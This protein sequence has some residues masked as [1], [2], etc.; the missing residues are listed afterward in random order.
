MAYERIEDHEWAT[1]IES[2]SKYLGGRH[3]EI[4][5]MGLDLGVQIQAEWVPLRSL[6]FGDRTGTLHVRLDGEGGIDHAI[7]VAEMWAELR[8]SELESL[9]LIDKSGHQQILRFRA[10]LELP[11]STGESDRGAAPP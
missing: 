7:D 6:H 8:G 1:F 10:P 3:V 9:A 4:E 2:F 11:A 5:V